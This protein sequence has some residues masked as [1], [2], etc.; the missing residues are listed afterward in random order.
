MP[1]MP[2]V[3]AVNSGAKQSNHGE[4][5][6][7]ERRHHA[8]F[9]TNLSVEAWWQDEFGSPCARAAVVKDA[10]VGGFGLELN[11]KPP[12]GAL[13]RVRT[14]ENS[15]RCVVRHVQCRDGRFRVGVEVLVASNTCAA[16]TKS[17]ARLAAVLS[18]AGRI[19][20]LSKTER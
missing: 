13:L 2:P 6:H 15:L 9:P 1:V 10:S 3:A 19:S 18:E 7:S 8:R 16:S 20:R 14:E 5:R 12:I 11:A 17:L 4:S